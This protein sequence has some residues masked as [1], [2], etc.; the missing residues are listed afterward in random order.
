M[1]QVDRALATREAQLKEAVELLTKKHGAQSETVALIQVRL[2][3]VQN[4][5]GEIVAEVSDEIEDTAATQS[6]AR[7]V[8]ARIPQAKDGARM[9]ILIGILIFALGGLSTMFILMIA[10]GFGK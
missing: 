1:A 10:L 8:R 5:I 9:F 7:F 4:E 2:K 6:D 3:E